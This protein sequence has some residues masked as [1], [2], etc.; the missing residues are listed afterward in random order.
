MSRPTEHEL[1]QWFIREKVPPDAHHNEQY[2][3][4]GVYHDL[5]VETEK[6]LWIVDAK[7]VVDSRNYGGLG[8][9]L[10]Y[11]Y[12]HEKYDPNETRELKL[13]CVCQDCRDPD[14]RELLGLYNVQLVEKDIEPSTRQRVT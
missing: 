2:R 1:I 11:K 14:L 13:I 6:E 3:F 9:L 12:L 5:V 8:Q 7:T 4:Y 10:F